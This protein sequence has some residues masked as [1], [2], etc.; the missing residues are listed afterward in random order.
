MSAFEVG[1]IYKDRSLP[2]KMMCY[3]CISVVDWLTH[4]NKVL[5]VT[6]RKKKREKGWKGRVRKGG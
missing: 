1:S 6:E 4:L 2:Q 5:D 3:G